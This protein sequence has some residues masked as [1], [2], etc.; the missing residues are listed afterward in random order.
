MDP[1]V[2]LGLVDNEGV[3][4]LGAQVREKLVR[5]KDSLL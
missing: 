3:A 5:V 2:I 1:A 4:E